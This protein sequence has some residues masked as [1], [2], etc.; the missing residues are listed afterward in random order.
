MSSMTKSHKREDIAPDEVERVETTADYHA[1]LS[2]PFT[3]R[4]L[5]AVQR[6]ANE[7]GVNATAAAQQLI[8]EPLAV[9]S[10]R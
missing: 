5:A 4:Q 2:V 7:R 9:R 8:D 1:E 10:H 6:I 3:A